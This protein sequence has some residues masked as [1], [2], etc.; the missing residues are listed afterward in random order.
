MSL[1][2]A[3]MQHQAALDANTKAMQ[4]MSILLESDYRINDLLVTDEASKGYDTAEI[5]KAILAA[6]EAKNNTSY[7]LFEEEEPALKKKTKSTKSTPQDV[8]SAPE[9]AQSTDTPQTTV[10]ASSAMISPSSEGPSYEV[11]APLI[12]RISIE[13]GITKAKEFLAEFG[14]K[15]L[16]ELEGKD[17]TRIHDAAI[18]VL[19]S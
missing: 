15:S 4:H 18:L 17:L 8:I 14:I 3:L 9:D 6:D 2:Q 12:T 5:E 13:K 7:L 19:A 16:R 11:T 1:E 10:P